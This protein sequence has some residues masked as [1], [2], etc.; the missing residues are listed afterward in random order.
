MKVLNYLVFSLLAA[1]QKI[2][3]DPVCFGAR[4][5][6]YGA[7]N[8]TKTGRVKTMKLIHKSGSL[9]CNRVDNDSYWGCANNNYANK[10][11]T[12]ITKANG[13]AFLPPAEDLEGRNIKNKTCFNKKHCYSL[14]GFGHKSPELVLPNPPSPLSLSRGQELQIWYGQDWINCSEENNSG[15]TCVDVYAWYI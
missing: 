4:D 2:N 14:K 11:M 12:I 7:F 1:W 9:R 15:S 3:T 8:M 5:N 10:M 13:E 6:K